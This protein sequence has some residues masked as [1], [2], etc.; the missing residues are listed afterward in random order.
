MC[1][2]DRSILGTAQFG[3]RIAIEEQ[4]PH[5]GDIRIDQTDLTV[6]KVEARLLDLQFEAA[7]YSPKSFDMTCTKP[8]FPPDSLIIWWKKIRIVGKHRPEGRLHN[9]IN[10]CV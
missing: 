7:G 10:R 2:R 3:N 9:T 4:P 5:R 1:I 8:Y 6:R